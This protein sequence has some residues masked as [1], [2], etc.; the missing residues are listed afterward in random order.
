VVPYLEAG[1]F[2]LSF[3]CKPQRFL[4]AGEKTE[5]FTSAG[6]LINLTTQDAKPLIRA[7]GTGSFGVGDAT[8]TISAADVYTDIDCDTQDAY[9]GNV[10]CNNK[11]TLTAGKFPV[12]KPGINNIYLSG[13]SKVEL[14]PRWWTI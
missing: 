8:M 3:D 1:E 11:I 14:T 13:V 2:K 10:N 6:M 7:Y 4:K 5:M 9:K 12:L